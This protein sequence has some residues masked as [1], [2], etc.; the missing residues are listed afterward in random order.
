MYG[1][2]FEHDK[3]CLVGFL[4]YDTDPS[5]PA[6]HGKGFLVTHGET[7]DTVKEGLWTTSIETEPTTVQAVN[8]L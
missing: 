6:L 7:E 4:S 3:N 2:I 1:R 8:N 5:K